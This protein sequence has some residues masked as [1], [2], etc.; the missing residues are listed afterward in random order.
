VTTNRAA[1]SA[2]NAKTSEETR[3]EPVRSVRG[4]EEEPAAKGGSRP[5]EGAIVLS[6]SASSRPAGA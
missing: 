4:T 3:N 1:P 5:R 2:T 6:E